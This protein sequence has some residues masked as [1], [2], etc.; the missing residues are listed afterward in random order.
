MLLPQKSA[1]KVQQNPLSRKFILQK[2]TS[3]PKFNTD[4]KESVSKFRHTL[5][6]DDLIGGIISYLVFAS[7]DY[8]SQPSNTS[9]P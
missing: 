9:G 7:N 4:K 2:I 8:F 6:Y 3:T 5:R 1:A